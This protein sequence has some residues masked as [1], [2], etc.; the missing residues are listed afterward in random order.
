MVKGQPRYV[1]NGPNDGYDNDHLEAAHLILAIASLGAVVVAA[2]QGTLL[3]LVVALALLVVVILILLWPKIRSAAA[4]YSKKRHQA[5][6]V[7]ENEDAFRRLVDDFDHYTRSRRSNITEPI[8]EILRDNERHDEFPEPH[9]ME[10]L[11]VT[12]KDFV[13]ASDLD[14]DNFPFFVR[15]LVQIVKYHNRVFVIDPIE[16]IEKEKLE[17]RDFKE[18]DYEKYHDE[19]M[20]FIKRCA[21]FADKTEE[22]FDGFYGLDYKFPRGRLGS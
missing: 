3:G 7:E 16:T 9:Y 2:A 15:L 5:R 11:Y 13:E 8:A 18:Q 4:S 22:H 10:A 14:R 1:G 17:V 21:E 6:F 20:H 19:Y 12:Y